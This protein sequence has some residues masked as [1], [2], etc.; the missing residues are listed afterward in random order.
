MRS[1]AHVLLCRIA[2][3]ILLSIGI[4]S[5][6]NVAFG[7]ASSLSS[8]SSSGSSGKESLRPEHS[9]A[10]FFELLD[11][12]G[13]WMVS[14]MNGR[15]EQRRVDNPRWDGTAT[16]RETVMTFLEAMRHIDMD[17]NEAWPRVE[18]TFAE[19][20]F[21]GERDRKAAAR[22]LN[23]V[24]KRLPKL[25]PSDLPG[26]AELSRVARERFELFPGQ[27]QHQWVWQALGKAPEGQ[28]VLNVSQEG[29]WK[30]SSETLRGAEKLRDSM[31]SIPPRQEEPIA[32]SLFVD[33]FA[34]L[35]TETVWWAWLVF[36][37]ASVGAATLGWCLNRLLSRYY[38]TSPVA[39]VFYQLSVP[40]T[41]LMVAIAVA[42]TSPLLDLGPLLQGFRSGLV[43]SLLLVGLGWLVIEVLDLLILA[44]QSRVLGNNDALARMGLSVARRALRVIV[45]TVLI[46]FLLQNTFDANLTA[47]FGGLG[48]VALAISL[49][50]QDV[51]KNLFGGFMVFFNRPFVVGDWVQFRTE[52]GEVEDIGLQVTRIRLLSGELWVVPNKHFTDDPVENLSMRKYLRREMNIAIPYDTSSDKITRALELL[53]EVL[54]SDEIAEAGEF[55]LE[56]RAPVITFSDLEDYYFNLK[57]YYWYFMSDSGR[58]MQRYSDRGWFSYL[59]HCTLVNRRIVEAFN[60]NDIPFAFPTQSLQLSD[61]PTRGLSV[62]MA[63]LE[64]EQEGAENTDT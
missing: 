9:S 51:F 55:D 26:E 57:V 3:A 34:P 47:L 58:R 25:Q 45:A 49:A 24:F 43:K 42:F 20:T 54:R 60:E 2:P 30:F 40:L 31:S 19:H 15:D 35:F 41:L 48:L 39:R 32:G 28:I 50:A 37:A 14:G 33:T 1:S 18:K 61:D 27:V 22:A 59:E 46:L 23:E 38:E 10:G 13:E 4:S 17:R 8:A 11:S 29:Q 62:E 63:T 56:N 64:S 21:S 53:D 36:A 7:Q 12:A 5:N 44:S 6:A 52:L 16:P